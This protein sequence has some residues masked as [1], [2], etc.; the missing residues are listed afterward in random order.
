LHN[1]VRLILCTYA[2]GLALS[3]IASFRAQAR[4]HRTNGRPSRVFGKILLPKLSQRCFC[5]VGVAFIAALLTAAAGIAARW[6]LAVACVL[7]FFYFGQIISLSYIRRKT[8]LAPIV[9]ALLLCAPGATA[10]FS[11]RSPFWPVLAIQI[12]VASVYLSAGLAKIRNSGLRWAL[13]SQLQAY[14]VENYLWRDSALAGRVAASGYFCT[15]ASSYTLCVELIFPLA[16][17]SPVLAVILIASVIGMHISTHILMNID[18]LR[19]W[20]PNYLPFLVP[21]V[22]S[23]A[24]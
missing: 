20:W 21:I 4:F 15:L 12:A 8:N 16:I 13:G 23:A 6:L 5:A 11:D 1:I 19:Y 3:A 24:R 9:L 22:L 17:V 2:T 10:P 14:L 7:Y 18:Y